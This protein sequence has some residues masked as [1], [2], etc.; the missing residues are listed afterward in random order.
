MEQVS[1]ASYVEANIQ[2][3]IKIIQN[4]T[5]YRKNIERLQKNIKDIDGKRNSGEVIWKFIDDNIRI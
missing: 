1:K 3:A 2:K 4:N 5:Y